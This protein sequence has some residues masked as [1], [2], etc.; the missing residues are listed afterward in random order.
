MTS[1]TQTLVPPAARAVVFDA[2]GTLIHPD[3]P[4][5]VVYSEVGKVFGSRLALD[6]IADRFR[7]AFAQQE[8]IDRVAGLHTSE[9]REVRRW[10]QIVRQVLDDV[11]DFESC[12]QQLFNH[13]SEADC[14]AA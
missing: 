6:E 3:P 8:E 1:P 10:R 11:S 14:V 2:V 9:E 5:A 7:R 4:A 13:F 12:F